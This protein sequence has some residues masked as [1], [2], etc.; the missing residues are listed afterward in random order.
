MAPMKKTARKKPVARKKTSKTAK[1]SARK[2]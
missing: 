1:K 2:R